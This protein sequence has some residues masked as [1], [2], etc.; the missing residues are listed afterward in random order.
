MLDSNFIEERW[1]DEPNLMHLKELLLALENVL[2][3]ILGDLL[4]WQHVVLST[5]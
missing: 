5:I 4:V 1:V 2:Q 3:E